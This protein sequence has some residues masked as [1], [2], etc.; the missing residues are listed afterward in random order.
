[1]ASKGTLN[2]VYGEFRK[3]QSRL[4]LALLDKI[5]DG[6]GILQGEILTGLYNFGGSCNETYSA[7]WVISVLVRQLN[8]GNKF[9]LM[10]ENPKIK[11]I[12]KKITVLDN[13]RLLEELLTTYSCLLENCSFEKSI[14]FIC[15]LAEKDILSGCQEL[16]KDACGEI[17]GEIAEKVKVMIQ[18]KNLSQFDSCFQKLIESIDAYE[19]LTIIQDILVSELKSLKDYSPAQVWLCAHLKKCKRSNNSFRVWLKKMDKN[20][21][22]SISN[23]TLDESYLSDKNSESSSPDPKNQQ[24]LL[25]STVTTHSSEEEKVEISEKSQ[26]PISE[27]TR[28]QEIEDTN[29]ADPT[30][31]KSEKQLLGD[32]KPMFPHENVNLTNQIW[33]DR[34]QGIAIAQSTVYTKRDETLTLNESSDKIAENNLPSE[35]HLHPESKVNK[36][37]ETSSFCIV[38]QNGDGP[39][40]DTGNKQLL[41]SENNTSEANYRDT[42]E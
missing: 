14:E 27:E 41:K 21:N 34:G 38:D 16:F 4:Y 10:Q 17:F 40:E 2:Y 35:N 42:N 26:D 39:N 22:T 7:D 31:S 33:G 29:S 37:N 6:I 12:K 19:D 18:S 24:P 3:N 32:P 20:L 28:A 11:L 25:E 8:I 36:M 13:D 23:K 9:G 15:G 30:D 1:M 5:F